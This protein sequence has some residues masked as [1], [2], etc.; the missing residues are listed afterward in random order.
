MRAG[1]ALT[2]TRP[3][4]SF[5]LFLT[6]ALGFILAGRN[7]GGA[8]I[9]ALPMLPIS[10]ASFC[11]NDIFD[12]ETDRINHPDRAL[13]S[14]PALSNTALTLYVILFLI[15]IGSIY[16]QDRPTDRF[17]WA[18]DFILLSNYSVFK[19]IFPL[20][21]NVYIASSA[22]IVF[23]ILDISNENSLHVVFRYGPLFISTLAREIA[24]D[25]P[26]ARGDKG[27]LAL[28]L[29]TRRSLLLTIALYLVALCTAFY[30]S[31]TSVHLFASIAGFILFFCYALARLMLG[32][33]ENTLRPV[34]AGVA[35]VPAV[36]I[37]I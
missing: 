32:W 31:I 2:T 10:L 15:S 1:A 8:L 4:P 25:I 35:T 30:L 19:R 13:A 18:I 28:K 22:C 24:L 12:Q 16:L 36:L 23:S 11:I 26:D 9:A 29:N 20:L 14:Y 6:I 37:A 34:S 7:W 5:A 27:T 33:Q 21:K 3:L 17:V